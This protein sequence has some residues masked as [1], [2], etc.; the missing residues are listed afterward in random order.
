MLDPTGLH[1]GLWQ[2]H[3]ERYAEWVRLNENRRLHKTV[4]RRAH[5]FDRFLAAVGDLLVAAGLKLKARYEPL[6]AESTST[7]SIQEAT[8]RK[9]VTEGSWSQ[10]L[11]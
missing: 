4:A 7:I 2:M 5:G 8:P 11:L 1:S 3:K 10:I 6:I 9:R